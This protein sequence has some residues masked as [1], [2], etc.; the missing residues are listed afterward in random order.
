MKRYIALGMF[1]LSSFFIFGC[2]S[3]SYDPYPHTDLTNEQWYRSVNTSAAP[4]AQGAS[5]W[6]LTGD[7]SVTEQEDD[8][9]PISSAI[10]TMMVRVGEF[11]NVKVDGPFNVQLFGTDEHNSVYVYGPNAGVREVV[12]EV[13]N[14][15][16]F[17]RPVKQGTNMPDM[18]KV[19]VRIGMTN[20][21]KLTSTGSGRV[22]GR[23]LRSNRLEIYSS[24]SGKMYLAGCI[25]LRCIVQSGCG[26]VNVF[27]A[28]A[29]V[30][31]ISTNG[32][33][34][35]NVSGNLGLRKITHHG[36]GNINII[37]ANGGGAVI[38]A[39]GSGKIGINGKVCIHE[40]T[41]RD[42]VCVY[43]YYVASDSL[44]VY[45]YDNARVGLAGVVNNLYVNA[46][47]ASRFEGRYL[48]AQNAYVKARDTSHVNVT[49]SNRIYAGAANGA[50][51]YFFGSPNIMS[52]FTKANGAVIPV[53]CDT[54]SYPVGMSAYIP[55]ESPCY[56]RQIC[57]KPRAVAYPYKD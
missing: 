51:I 27:G 46:S 35:V 8:A 54:R 2:A 48:H 44:N 43:A 33:G 42:R 4:W 53:W 9:A 49:A 5:S 55:Y 3:R 31:D 14:N 47:G 10:S 57:S 28:T 19:I 24:G 13:R 36:S 11:N 16:L 45:T 6:F 30:L 25:K 39:D 17:I 18:R 41:A 34:C 12:V 40:I 50:T 20:L 15:T 23:Q 56:A 37:G 26:T 52:Q 32:S 7:P 38:Y 1:I 29:P 21:S 22:E